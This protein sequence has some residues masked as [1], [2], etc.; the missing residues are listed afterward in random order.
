MPNFDLNYPMIPLSHKY[1]KL[2][3]YPS[4]PLC[5]RDITKTCN[6]AKNTSLT[7]NLRFSPSQG[8]IQATLPTHKMVLTKFYDLRANF[9]DFTYMVKC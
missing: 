6:L 3:G 7:K 9:V 4:G 5:K 8:G 2:I 1:E